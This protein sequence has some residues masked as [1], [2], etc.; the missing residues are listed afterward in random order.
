VP[1][2]SN[3]QVEPAPGEMAVTPVRPVTSTGVVEHG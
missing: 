2:E 3:A 1:F